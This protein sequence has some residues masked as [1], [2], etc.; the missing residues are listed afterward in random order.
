MKKLHQ[1]LV[2]GI[3]TG[4]ASCVCATE[5]IVLQPEPWVPVQIEPASNDAPDFSGMPID[6]RMLQ[7]YD[8]SAANEGYLGFLSSDSAIA[9]WIL[10][11][12]AL[13]AVLFA[14]FVLVNGRAKLQDGFSGNLIDRWSIGDV[15]VHWFAAIPGLFLILTG[16]FIGSGWMWLEPMMA[17]HT[18]TVFIKGCVMIHNAFGI[19]FAVALV[20]LILK[21][22][23]RQIPASYDWA[24]FRCLGGYINNGK[25]QHPDAGFAN[26]GEK[27]YYWCVTVFGLILTVTGLLMMWPD[28]LG[29]TRNAI[30]LSLVLH[31]VSSVVLIAF[32]VVHVYMGAVMSEGGIENM[33]S[34]KCDENWARQNHNLWFAKQSLTAK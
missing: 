8:P 28:S 14:L 6:G 10:A 34:G 21:Y 23:P 2:A 17:P 22:M 15:A 31:I 3:G 26:A 9:L 4:L 13:V 30:L 20:I 12:F 25:N 1:T 16:L 18:W 11:A 27:A 5:K 29:I 32:T 33:L 19:P 7:S 24:W